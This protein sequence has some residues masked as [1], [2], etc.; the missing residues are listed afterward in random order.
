[1]APPL[2]CE[3]WAFL[4]FLFS[5]AMLGIIWVLVRVAVSACCQ[6]GSSSGAL[7]GLPVLSSTATFAMLLRSTCKFALQ[8]SIRPLFGGQSTTK[9]L[10][11]WK[12]LDTPFSSFEEGGKWLFAW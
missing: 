3:C 8:P 9:G 1:M 10:D 5:V 2:D 7:H 6:L 12:L 4:F 11:P